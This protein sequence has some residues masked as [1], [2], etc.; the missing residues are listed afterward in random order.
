MPRTTSLLTLA[1]LA[2]IISVAAPSTPATAAQ[3]DTF[4]M[5]AAEKAP[6]IVSIKFILKGGDMDEENETTGVVV[7][8][9]GIILTSN[10][11]F[12]GLMAR[13]G[14]PAVSP[15]DIKVLIGDD[16]QGLDATFVARDSELGLAWIRLKTPPA[17][18]LSHIDFSK[19]TS[20]ELGDSIYMVGLMGKFFDRAPS[21]SEGRV[22]AI[23]RKPRT[24]YIPSI[25]LAGTEQG[26]P[27]F[28]ADGRPIGISTIIFPEQ[29]EL[30]GSPGG[31]R[32]AMRGVTGSMILPAADVADATERAISVTG[33]N[34]EPVEIDTNDKDDS[35]KAD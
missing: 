35:G 3:P 15:S 28:A 30:A 31:V 26:I 20:P 16:T 29:E 33:E 12:G 19:G 34:D 10:L 9:R 18:P 25:G 2:A 24:L 6:A 14:G 5:L 32:A 8:P 7:D 17:T 22:G 1:L 21:I 27:V 4:K 23:A 13:F 11:A